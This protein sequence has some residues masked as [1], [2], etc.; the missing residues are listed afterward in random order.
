M[1]ETDPTVIAL[2]APAATVGACGDEG[3]PG[4]ETGGLVR[5]PR[6]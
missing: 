5:P 3:R 2:V 1:G 6:P 4:P